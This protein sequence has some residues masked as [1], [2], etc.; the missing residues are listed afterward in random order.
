LEG[1]EE[2]VHPTPDP[3]APLHVAPGAVGRVD[4][5]AAEMLEGEVLRSVA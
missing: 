1:S 2:L 4:G 5:E 3:A